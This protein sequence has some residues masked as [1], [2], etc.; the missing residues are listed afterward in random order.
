MGWIDDLAK[1]GIGGSPPEKSDIDS[2]ATDTDDTVDIDNTADD[3]GKD[4]A[5]DEPIRL[6]SRKKDRKV[7]AYLDKSTYATAP[8]DHQDAV[9]DDDTAAVPAK[10]VTA[11]KPK[12]SKKP[13]T[14]S[15]PDTARSGLLSGWRGGATA[16]GVMVLALGV[17]GVFGVRAMSGTEAV[18]ARDTGQSSVAPA[19][20]PTDHRNLLPDADSAGPADNEKSIGGTCS[21]VE[22]SELPVM[23]ANQRDIRGAWVTYNSEL[24]AHNAEGI[25]AVLSGDSSMRD[26]DW[27]AVF[28]QV[29]KGATF[30]LEMEKVSGKQV[31]GHLSV[32][33]ADGETTD[34][35]Q[36]ATGVDVDGRWFL[37]DIT[38]DSTRGTRA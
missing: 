2:T 35:Y 16:I 26:Q 21:T 1:Q 12:K 11:D 7:P 15:T 5:G 34:Y 28:D 13:R 31:R 27:P 10:R 30:C 29:D 8:V 38:Q 25:E 20:S 9:E 36:K 19:P 23:R 33:T 17:A 32:T 24:Y 4:G 3:G 6:P 37:K 14:Q 18:T 22:D